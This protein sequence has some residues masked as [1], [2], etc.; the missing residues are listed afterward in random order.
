MAP[1]GRVGGEVEPARRDLAVGGEVQVGGG[2]V[3]RTV[4]MGRQPL[5]VVRGELARPLSLMTPKRNRSPRQSWSSS[6]R[7][8]AAARRS[9][10]SSAGT[11]TAVA[12]AGGDADSEALIAAMVRLRRAAGAGSVAGRPAPQGGGRCEGFA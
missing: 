7:A 4:A 2:R 6:T 1:G 9:I 5:L 12:R 11:A 3:A 8:Y 10:P